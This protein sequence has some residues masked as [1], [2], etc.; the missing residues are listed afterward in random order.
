MTDSTD[1]AFSSADYET[2]LDVVRQ[3]TQPDICPV[4][5]Q[6]D[7]VGRLGLAGIDTTVAGDLI[8]NL[9]ATDNLVRWEYDDGR[10]WI[11]LHEPDAIQ[12]SLVHEAE[13]RSQPEPGIAQLNQALADGESK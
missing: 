13:Q 4:I 10:V 3:R 5:S 2:A 6:F 8:D 9:V 12:R 11:C 7:L 1:E